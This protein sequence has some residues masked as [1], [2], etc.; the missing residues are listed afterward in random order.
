MEVSKN[1]TNKNSNI[2]DDW[3]T[4]VSIGGAVNICI[5]DGDYHFIC[6]LCCRYDVIAQWQEFNWEFVWPNAKRKKQNLG[7]GCC[8]LLWHALT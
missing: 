6:L 2:N 5:I 8:D 1:K 7:G 3:K 4:M